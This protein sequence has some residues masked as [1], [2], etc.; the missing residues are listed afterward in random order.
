M[1]G[2]PRRRAVTP[3]P[4]PWCSRTRRS[5]D[6]GHDASDLAASL[7]TTTW[8]THTWPGLAAVVRP[9]TTV[10]RGRSG[11]ALAWVA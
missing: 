5:T 2:S 1:Q 6:P 8:T 10:R 11:T 4:V 9:H 7:C 3:L